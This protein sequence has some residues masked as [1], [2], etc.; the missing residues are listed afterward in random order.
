MSA[1]LGIIFKGLNRTFIE[2][3]GPV[4]LESSRWKAEALSSTSL[5]RA[6][7]R[8]DGSVFLYMIWLPVTARCPVWGTWREAQTAIAT[9]FWKRGALSIQWLNKQ[10]APSCFKETQFFENRTCLPVLRGLSK[11]IPFWLHVSTESLSLQN[12]AKLGLGKVPTIKG[13]WFQRLIEL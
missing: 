2:K 7:I 9:W 3:I 13:H 8:A 1:G 6:K 11:H 10:N 12:S 4:W 5:L